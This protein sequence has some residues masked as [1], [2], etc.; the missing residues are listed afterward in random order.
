MSGRLLFA[1]Q[2]A[3]FKAL[4]EQGH[5]QLRPRHGIVMAYLEADG[6][7]ASDLAARAGQHKQVVGS[8][9]DELEILGYVTRRPDPSDR[10]AKLVV[11]TAL[12]LD[13]M[14]KARQIVQKIEDIYRRAIGS[15][16]FDEFTAAFEEITEVA[17]TLADNGPSAQPQ[18]TGMSRIIGA[19]W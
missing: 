10:R 6:I 9:I 5:A 8:I 16:R 13:Q 3:L 1:F 7:R 2:E 12:G 4:A 15:S 17:R 11:P 14:V 18:S 19:G